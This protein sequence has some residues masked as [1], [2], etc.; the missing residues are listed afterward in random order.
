MI[1]TARSLHA[2]EDFRKLVQYPESRGLVAL[3]QPLSQRLPPHCASRRLR[4]PQQPATSDTGRANQR[5]SKQATNQQPA[6][7]QPASSRAI[8]QPAAPTSNQ[9]ASSRA[10]AATGTGDQPRRG[11]RCRCVFENNSRHHK[12][13][14]RASTALVERFLLGSESSSAHSWRPDEDEALAACSASNAGLP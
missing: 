8:Q 5:P 2:L 3:T 14:K 13:K 9:S 6:S 10:N 11:S 12:P 1:C 4:Q 7:S